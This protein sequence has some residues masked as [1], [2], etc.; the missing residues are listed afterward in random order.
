MMYMDDA[1]RA[2]LLLMEAPSNELKIRTS[3]NLSGLSFTP[4]ALAAEIQ[5]HYPNFQVNYKPDF[6][7]AIADSWPSTIDDRMARMDWH[8][9]QSF[10]LP[11]MTLE[12]LKGLQR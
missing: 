12:M 10:D 7:Q 8:W 2:T 4:A 9:Q 1:I 3:Y 11:K 5:I 6:R